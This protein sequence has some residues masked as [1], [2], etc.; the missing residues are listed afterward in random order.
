MTSAFGKKTDFLKYRES[1]L[2]DLLF[3]N[4]TVNLSF[5]VKV[6]AFIATN[7]QAFLSQLP[8]AIVN[9]LTNK[10]PFLKTFFIENKETDIFDMITVIKLIFSYSF[11]NLLTKKLLINLV[12]EHNYYPIQFSSIIFTYPFKLIIENIKSEINCP[13][14][15]KLLYLKSKEEGMED[16]LFTSQYIKFSFI[17][18]IELNIPDH[19]QL[20]YIK[21]LKEVTDP[22][23][24]NGLKSILKRLSPEDVFNFEKQFYKF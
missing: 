24:Y 5:E 2:E 9:Q 17:E 1:S 20:T 21:N 10:Q 6:S 3:I 14:F 12:L 8:D 18:L 15:K 11:T 22:Y 19:H 4:S 13:N 23:E 7:K 16:L